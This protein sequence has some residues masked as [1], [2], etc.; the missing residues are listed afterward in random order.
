MIN[1]I[2]NAQTVFITTHIYADLDALASAVA[3]AELVKKNLGKPYIIIENV[4]NTTREMLDSPYAESIHKYIITEE[5][6]LSLFNSK[7][8]L[9]LTDVNDF[10]RS[11]APHLYQHLHIKNKYIIDHHR[12]SSSI[13]EAHLLNTHIDIHASSAAEIAT[14]ILMH[15]TGDSISALDSNIAT[16]ITAGIYLDTNTLKKATSPRTFDALSFLSSNGA[17]TKFVEDILKMSSE[18]ASILEH[19]YKEFEKIGRNSIFVS[20]PKNVEVPAE[21]IS[22][23]ANKLLDIRKIQSVIVV[24]KVK[25][26]NSYKMSVRSLEGFNSQLFAETLNGGGHYDSAA[27]Q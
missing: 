10:T 12:V 9:I 3:I 23:I 7:S 1:S 2:K 8:L 18:D 5:E 27:M 24:G 20:L 26:Q 16:I 4:D 6:A 11:Q 15:D 14:E 19:A 22:I 25:D 17:A 21:S 13:E